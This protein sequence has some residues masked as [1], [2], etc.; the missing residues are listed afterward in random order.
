MSKIILCS[1]KT[2]ET[3]FTFLNTKV[4]IYTYEELC[5][6]IY[7]NTVL[8]SKS[9][10]SD[11]LFD[12]IRV[13]LGMEELADKLVGLANKTSYAQDLLIEI[14]S[15]GEYYTIEEIKNYAEAW[16]KYRK[17]DVLQKSKLKADGYLAYRRYIKAATFYDDI[18][19]ETDENTDPVFLGN[20]YHNRA[21]AAANN[22]DLEDAK[23]FFLKAYEKNENTESLKSYF[24]IVAITSDTSTL[25]MEIRRQ[26]LPDDYL[27][28]IMA[29]IG[30]SKDD[31]REM[32]I[33]AM[34]QRAAYNKMNKDMA[35]YDKRMDIILSELKDD[36]R[37][38]AI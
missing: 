15:A 38:Q 33:F 18:I 32:T 8:I 37:E 16:Q 6:Y 3:P 12:W 1:S 10:L 25:K 19:D 20:I 7:N 4:E 2:A 36:F 27:E 29:E 31:V 30:E 14:L 9:S 24:Y 13:E 5:F 35:D 11:K 21:V 23:Q 34:L 22:M 28:E 17:L 26:G